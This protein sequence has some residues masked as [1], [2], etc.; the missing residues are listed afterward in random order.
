VAGAR[1]MAGRLVQ[2]FG[3]PMNAVD[4]LT[5]LFPRAETLAQAGSQSPEIPTICP[6]LLIAVAAPLESPE[7]SGSAWG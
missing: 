7:I 5:H 4:P 3:V 1:T 6:L 2:A